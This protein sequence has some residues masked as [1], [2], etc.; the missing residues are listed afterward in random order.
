M[1]VAARPK[2]LSAGQRRAATLLVLRAVRLL[3]RLAMR[4]R[5]GV[6][7]SADECDELVDDLFNIY[8]ELDN[9]RLTE[10]EEV[11]RETSRT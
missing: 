8:G 10:G 5:A 1:P 7:L 3:S 4:E 6:E 11:S 9:Y 2:M